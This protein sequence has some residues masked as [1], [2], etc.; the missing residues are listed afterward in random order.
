MHVKMLLYFCS[1]S[2]LHLFEV[3]VESARKGTVLKMVPFK[4]G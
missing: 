2:E 3:E 1:V 4:G